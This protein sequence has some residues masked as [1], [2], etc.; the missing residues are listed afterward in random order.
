MSNN[1]NSSDTNTIYYE[2]L[3]CKTKI[4][5]KPGFLCCTNSTCEGTLLRKH[6]AV[7]TYKC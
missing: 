1:E 7:E 2:C 6:Y 5:Y 3:A 4:P